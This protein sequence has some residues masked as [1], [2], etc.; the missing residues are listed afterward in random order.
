M[1]Q[2]KSI[3]PKTDPTGNPGSGRPPRKE[4]MSRKD[5]RDD[6]RRLSRKRDS[7]AVRSARMDNAAYG[8]T[9]GMRTHKKRTS[10]NRSSLGVIALLGI[11]LLILIPTALTLHNTSKQLAE[12]KAMQASLETQREELQTSVNDLKSQ[13]DIVNTD[14]FIEKYAHEKLGMLRPNEILMDMGDG[15]VKINEDAL[16]KYKAEQEQK[17]SA[18]SSSAPLEESSSVQEDSGE[19]Y[20][21][22][23]APVEQSPESSGTTDGQ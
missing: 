12:T 14:Q 19:G 23:T 10:L 1:S 22:T 15:K 9:D 18:A 11:L 20:G 7:R 8:T 6:G 3:L 2:F 13:L 17:A 21:L 4:E 5:K 16:A